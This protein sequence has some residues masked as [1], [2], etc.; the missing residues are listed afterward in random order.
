MNPL[1][2]KKNCSTKNLVKLQFLCT[3][4]RV[5]LV[6]WRIIWHFL[7]CV[8]FLLQIGMIYLFTVQFLK[9]NNTTS[10]EQGEG[11][12]WDNYFANGSISGSI[13]CF[14]VTHH[15]SAHLSVGRTGS[16]QSSGPHDLEHHWMFQ[17]YQ[18]GKLKFGLTLI[19][20]WRTFQNDFLEQKWLLCFANRSNLNSISFSS[21]DHHNFPPFYNLYETS[22]KPENTMEIVKK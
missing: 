18:L 7:D 2:L 8:Y 16:K 17:F 12:D 5:T 1:N 20:S 10:T 22:K 19:W 6:I 13:F 4:Q 9:R 14:V 3:E 15:S 11:S 21:K